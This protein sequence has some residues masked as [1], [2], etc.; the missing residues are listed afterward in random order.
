MFSSNNLMQGI[1]FVPNTVQSPETLTKFFAFF[2]GGPFIFILAGIVA[3][4]RFKLSP[5]ASE[6]LA[7]ELVRLRA[8]G[9]KADASVETISVCEEVSGKPYAQCWT[10]D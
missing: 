4:T 1:R 2:I 10:R 5:K 7:A 8:G 6:I 9:S 3:A